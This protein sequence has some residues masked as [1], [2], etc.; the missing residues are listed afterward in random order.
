[1]TRSSRPS[2]SPSTGYF[3]A[4]VMSKVRGNKGNVQQTPVLQGR[5]VIVKFFPLAF[6]F[7]W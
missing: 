1:M 4:D 5:Y 2:P 3:S 6:T 7:V